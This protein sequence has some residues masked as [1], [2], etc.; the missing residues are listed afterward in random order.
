MVAGHAAAGALRL[1]PRGHH[2]RPLSTTCDALDSGNDL[3]QIIP[4]GKVSRRIATVGGS[5]EALADVR[6]QQGESHLWKLGAQL[7]SNL[8]DVG[9]GHF[10]VKRHHIRARPGHLGEQILGIRQSRN[11][12]D[13]PIKA[14]LNLDPFKEKG[15]VIDAHQPNHCLG[16]TG[17][18]ADG[19]LSGE[20]S[21]V[22]WLH[23]HDEFLVNHDPAVHK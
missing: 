5:K 4:L 2:E 1:Y 23:L 8:K 22:S 18:E 9:T 15:V 17:D 10:H 20:D 11:K 14:H 19:L 12:L 3:A 7:A 13:L 16:R 6:C 21:G